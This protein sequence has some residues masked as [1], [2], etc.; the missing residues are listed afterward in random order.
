M[1]VTVGVEDLLSESVAKRL[2]LDYAPI[3]QEIRTEGKTG[4]GQLKGRFSSFNMIARYREPVLLITDLDNPKS[5]PIALI[6]EWSQG[7]EIETDLLFRVVV[8]EIETWLLADRVGMSQW[9]E[10]SDVLIQRHPESITQPKETL[11]GLAR[12]S[13]NRRLREAIVP[14]PGSTR[15]VGPGYNDCLGEFAVQHWNIEAARLNSPS[16]DRAIV[17]ID[18][19]AHRQS[20]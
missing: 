15:S 2:L 7:F 12:R 6:R 9:L 10:V 20:P 1:R 14:P 5:C 11:V 18:E 8:V 16:L 4:Y 3:F 13:P 19:L 17:R